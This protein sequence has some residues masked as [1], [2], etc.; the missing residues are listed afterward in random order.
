MGDQGLE[1]GQ[2]EDCGC[3]LGEFC[4]EDTVPRTMAGDGL[5]TFT[6]EEW[7]AIRRFQI[8]TIEEDVDVV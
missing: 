4:Q 1:V 3:G 6:A 8:K 2:G 5:V 7:A